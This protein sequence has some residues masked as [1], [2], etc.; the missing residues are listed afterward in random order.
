MLEF[1]PE[2]SAG[3]DSTR[4]F[5]VDKSKGQDSALWQRARQCTMAAISRVVKSMPA[6]CI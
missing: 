3:I 6:F 1:K 5:Y 4:K 2:K